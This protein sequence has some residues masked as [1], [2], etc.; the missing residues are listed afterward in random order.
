MK[1]IL[2]RHGQKQKISSQVYEERRAVC[3]TKKG[4]SQL[5]SLAS[6]LKRNFPK[7]IGAEKIYSSPLPRAI[8]SAE[9]VR[10]TLEINEIIPVSAFTEYYAFNNYLLSHE[11]RDALMEKAIINLDWKPEASSPLNQHLL[12]AEEAIKN[13]ASP[14]NSEYILISTHGALIRNFVYKIAPEL[15]PIDAEILDA[16]IKEGGYT[17]IEYTG[18]EFKLLEFDV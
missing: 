3:L 10:E 7:L 17:L 1:L 11:E 12:N 8:Q 6:T 2:F 5:E 4:I 14:A 18:E 15:K 9:I 16:K 13:I